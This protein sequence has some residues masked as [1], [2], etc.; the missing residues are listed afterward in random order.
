MKL[1]DFDYEIPDA[2]IAQEPLEARDASRLLVVDRA[3]GGRTHRVFREL[4]SLLR[5]GD[6]LVVNDTRV[7]PVR[8]IG[9][10]ADTGG[11]VEFL[12]VHRL[13]AEGQHTW[14]CI[15]QASK[16]IREG[17]LLL[18]GDVRAE[19]VASRGEGMYD[20][21]F[22]ACDE[23]ALAQVGRVPLP[24]YIRREPSAQDGERYQTVYARVPGSAA[25]PTAGLHFTQQILEE[26]EGQGIR[27]A[28]VTLHVGPG[29]FLPIR[30]EIGDHRMHEE[31]Y[32]VPS[33]TA[34][35]IAETRAR[36]GRVVAVG[37]TSL[38]ALESC[39]AGGSVRAGEGTTNLFV[40]PGF[41]FNVVDALLTNFHLPQSTLLL[42]VCA[43]GGTDRVLAAYREAVER[44]YRFY[45]YGDAMLVS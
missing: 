31:R 8:L 40:F 36:G 20:V 39:A 28:S 14:R 4:P 25:A 44:R 37:T 15:G 10:K 41:R 27:R 7:L 21:R 13:G 19:V 3:T 9:R 16:P 23:D 33:S 45:S 30:G 11:R 42:L 18:F 12:L 35:A 32:E 34:E 6:L 1:E 26:L 5:A 38:R 17:M 24:S 29:T 22:P 2:C 43:F